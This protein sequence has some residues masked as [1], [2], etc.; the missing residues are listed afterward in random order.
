MAISARSSLTGRDRSHGRLLWWV[1]LA[2]AGL[3]ILA[4]A[5]QPTIGL[6]V[7][8]A[9]VLG[10]L[11]LRSPAL[12]LA[13]SGSAL[14]ALVLGG[15]LPKGGTVALYAAW[16]LFG[17][18]V[19]LVRGGALPRLQ[20]V[21][22][23]GSVSVVALIGLLLVR[24]P[25]SGDYAYGWNKVQLM[26]VI[27]VVPMLAGI[28]VGY[29]AVDR[30]LLLATTALVGV[31]TACYGA[32]L[33]STGAASGANY[34]RLSLDDSIDPI[35]LGRAMGTVILVLVFY[36]I[37]ARRARS[38]LL[39]LAGVLP[40]AVVLIGSGSRGPLLGVMIGLPVLVIGLAG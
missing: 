40:A 13:L 35:G 25:A 2:I 23:V 7:V 30:R 33:V 22:N 11:A 26:L 4:T 29:R 1:A 24:L 5:S 34:D 21:L 37:R 28:V 39:A 8:A 14:A 20:R 6:G 36:F 16:I 31:A 10:A 9:G 17:V 27:G 15:R 38:R 19:A 18:V 12:P 3:I 32:V